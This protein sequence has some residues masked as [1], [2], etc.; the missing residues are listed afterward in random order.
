MPCNFHHR[1]LA[2]KVKEGIRAAGGTPM[3]FNTIA[4][5]DGITMGTSGH[6]EPRSISREVIADSI[7]LVARGH[8]FDAVIAISRLRQDD[9]RHRDGARAAR[10]ARRDA[11]RRLDPARPLPRQG[12][13]DPGGLRGGRRARRG[14][15]HRRGAARARGARPAPAPAPAAASSPPTRWRWRSSCSASRPIGP[16]DGPR[17][18]RTSQGRRPPYE[19]GELVMDVLAARP[20]PERHHHP[21]RARERDRRRRDE[22]RLDQRA[23]CT[24]SPSPARPASS[25]TSTTSTAS[26]PRRRCCATSSRAAASSPPTCYA[27]GGVAARRQA[28][29]RGRPAARGRD[30]RDRQDDRRARPR[31]HRDARARRSSARSTTRSSPPAASRSCAAT[32]RPRAAS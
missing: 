30:H 23:C 27:A 9:P 31:G 28:P 18:A 29:R 15:D 5:S 4:I 19:A 10:P 13:D 16:S 24:C 17:R 32:S 20:A 7:E 25:S 26:P 6:E 2:A 12:R 21:R 3:E 11:L 1:A 8:L 22:R 14:Q